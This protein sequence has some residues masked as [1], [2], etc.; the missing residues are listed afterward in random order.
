M[1]LL[2]GLRHQTKQLVSHPATQPS[3]ARLPFPTF[4]DLRPFIPLSEQPSLQQPRPSKQTCT[5]WSPAYP[6]CL[7]SPQCQ[8]RPGL[9]RRMGVGEPV[10]SLQFCHEFYMKIYLCVYPFLCR[11]LSFPITQRRELLALAAGR[12]ALSYKL[13]NSFEHG[14]FSTQKGR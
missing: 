8:R 1:W 5:S 12:A 3:S 2:K 6:G 13:E 7:P 10:L 4:A 14:P 11:A 9:Q